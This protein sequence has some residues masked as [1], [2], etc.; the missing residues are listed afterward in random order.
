M[1][2]LAPAS[3]VAIL[4]DIEAIVTTSEGQRQAVI[5]KF[6]DAGIL[7]LPD[8]RAVADIVRTTKQGK[9]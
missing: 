7:K 8:G 1:A 9:P 2:A 4:S 5:G 3:E 6:A